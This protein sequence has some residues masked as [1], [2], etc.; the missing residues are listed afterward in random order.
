MLA[1]AIAYSVTLLGPW[2]K[3]K[4]WANVSEFG[5]WAGFGII[6]ASFILSSLVV[7]PAVYGG[8]IAIS[9]KVSGINQVSFKEFFLRYS[10]T[11]VPL[12]LIAWIAYSLPLVM[13]NG[14]YIL[15]VLSD[16][17]GKGWDLFHTAK[18]PWT[19]ILPEWIPAIQVVILLI[20]LVYAV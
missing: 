14:S 2:G 13:V 5:N 4:E 15:A 12:G 8:F 9:R 3:L 6:A 19:P 18:V 11:L 20:G 16:P 7:F 17:F 10:Y 1:L